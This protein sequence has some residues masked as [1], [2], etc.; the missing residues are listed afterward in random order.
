MICTCGRETTGTVLCE[1]V[2]DG[3]PA[4]C[5]TTLAHAVAN[6]SVYYA[7]AHPIDHRQL[8][9]GQ[10]D[11]TKRWAFEVDGRPVGGV[12]T[13]PA[14]QT[15][16]DAWATVVAWCRIHMEQRRDLRGPTCA[17]ACLHTSCAE[18]RRR[19]YP[20]N[21]VTSMAHYLARQHR[22]T[23]S[24]P[25]APVMLDELLDVERR[26]RRLVDIP[27]PKWYAGRCG[28]ELDVA[29]KLQHALHGGDPDALYCE[30]E[31]YAS[32]ERGTI[33]C[34]M[35]GIEHDVAERRDYLLAQAADELVTASTAAA[36]LVAWTDYDGD[37]G[38]LTKRISEWRD[39]DRLEVRDVTS[40][41]GR[42]RHLY[43]LGDIQLLLAGHV[44]RKQSREV[45]AC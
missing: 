43:R 36:A 41:A 17:D 42:D 14:T 4:G 16:W 19:A 21:T 9:G 33:D 25:W 22:W 38:R 44:R 7:H 8:H 11:P 34:P 1:Y 3:K 27:A 12:V 37:P 5:A 40:L 31:L 26:L 6:I 29:G 35:C 30:A 20:G 13:M 18:I 10:P 15:R 23:I 32:T 39:R 2:Q 28:V 24:Q 45:N